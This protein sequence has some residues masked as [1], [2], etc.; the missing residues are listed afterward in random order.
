LRSPVLAA[1]KDSRVRD[2]VATRVLRKSSQDLHPE[3][4]ADRQ[5][6]MRIESAATAV[7]RRTHHL[8]PAA[9]HAAPDPAR[10]VGRT[11]AAGHR[12]APPRGP[13]PRLNRKVLSRRPAKPRAPWKPA[14]TRAPSDEPS[15]PDGR[16]RPRTGHGSAGQPYPAEARQIRAGC[17]VARAASFHLLARRH[18][19]QHR[20]DRLSGLGWLTMNHR[21]SEG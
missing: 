15:H 21:S 16:T 11:P 4:H 13:G 10:P 5:S 7:H 19:R 14:P 8:V 17:H 1:R 2:C 6:A 3:D 9:Q 12:P 20:P 18:L